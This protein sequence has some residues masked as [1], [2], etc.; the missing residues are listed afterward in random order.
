ME[1]LRLVFVVLLFVGIA[2]FPMMYAAKITGA[3]RQGFWDSFFSVLFSS[4]A[5]TA[6]VKI[7]D[8]ELIG[9]ALAIAASAFMISIILGAT[10]WQSVV[11]AIFAH[12][13][14]IGLLLVLALFGMAVSSFQ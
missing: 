1:L 5:A 8:N 11:I 6:A 7:V 9:I 12:A 14:R 4:I 13:L 10:F 2:V 3:R